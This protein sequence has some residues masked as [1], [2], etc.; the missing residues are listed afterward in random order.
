[1]SESQIAAD[2]RQNQAVFLNQ[3]LSLTMSTFV[4]CVAVITLDRLSVIGTL[5]QHYAR[6]R[7]THSFVGK[8]PLCGVAGGLGDSAGALALKLILGGMGTSLFRESKSLL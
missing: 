7:C 5:F 4:A 1:M 8:R 3:F 2:A 6:R